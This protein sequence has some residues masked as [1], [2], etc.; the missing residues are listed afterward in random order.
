MSHPGAALDS[1]D[2]EMLVLV[3]GAQV[4][5]RVA[6][7]V[8]E[9][10]QLRRQG[11]GAGGAHGG[12]HL[13]DAKGVG[14][15]GGLPRRVDGVLGQQPLLDGSN[16]A[17]ADGIDQQPGSQFVTDVVVVGK[18]GLVGLAGVGVEMGEAP[19]VDLQDKAA[20]PL[21]QVVASKGL[22][23]SDQFGQRGPFVAE[24]TPGSLS[25]CLGL[26]VGQGFGRAGE[27]FGAALV[28][29]H[30]DG[31]TPLQPFVQIGK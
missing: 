15:W 31:V 29:L 14:R 11:K 4:G 26:L 24:E 8:D 28:L 1:D 27:G 22:K 7:L 3:P 18:D 16:R 23:R 19:V 9:V 2:E 30:Q 21:R 13:I 6:L 17:T 10:D 25:L 20:L 5:H 12:Q